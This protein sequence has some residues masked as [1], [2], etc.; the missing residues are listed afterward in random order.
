MSKTTF[1][2]VYAPPKRGKTFSLLS[3]LPESVFVARPGALKPARML[4]KAQADAILA[5]SVPLTTVADA[6]TVLHTHG[7]SATSIV[8]DDFNFAVDATLL[9]L[10]TKHGKSWDRFDELIQVMREFCSLADEVD[11]VVFCSHHEMNPRTVKN[12]QT[13]V[14]TVLAGGP[15]VPGWK[16]PEEYPAWM[17]MVIRMVY[18]DSAPSW[19]YVYQ[20][21]PDP[22]YVTGDRTGISPALF[23]ANLGVLLRESGYHVPRPAGLAWMDK[24]TTSVS[25]KVL[26]ILQAED[27]AELHKYLS[28]VAAK[29]LSKGIQPEHVKWAI[30]D[31]YDRARLLS[32]Q[33]SLVDDFITALSGALT[34]DT[35]L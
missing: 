32:A 18:D 2:C 23:P 8:F 33:A 29:L 6:L 35:E 22:D 31:A 13:K 24:V 21:G 12:K 3:G 17:S 19:P 4:G 1:G 14:E 7:A 30:R 26:P 10:T 20:T 15:R 5:R 25:E 9:Q 34:D 16:L 28:A 27:A 11:A